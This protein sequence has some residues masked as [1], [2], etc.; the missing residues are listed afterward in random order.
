MKRL[1]RNNIAPN[2]SVDTES[3][4]R[5]I[6]QFRNTPD[7]STGTSPAE[8]LFGRTL[9]DVLPIRPPMQMDQDS[10]KPSWKHLWRSRE[11]ALRLRATK[12]MDSLTEKSRLAEPLRV[13]DLCRIQNQAGRYP[14][15]WDKL[16]TVVEVATTTNTS[17]GFTAQTELPFVTAGF[18]EACLQT[19][20]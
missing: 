7:P 1:L 12:Q 19:Q 3:F 18:S 20:P 9:R 13:G 4:T 15:R 14:R 8:V 6:L 5:A 11:D 17:S 16:G 2:G 10:V